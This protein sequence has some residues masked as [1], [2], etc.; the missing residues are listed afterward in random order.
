[1]NYSILFDTINLEPH[2]WNIGDYISSL[3]TVYPHIVFGGKGALEYSM[4][5]RTPD[6]CLYLLYSKRRIAN[7]SDLVRMVREKDYISLKF[8]VSD[9]KLTNWIITI[10]E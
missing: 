1:M 9:L 2:D 5:S 7:D 4:I 10:T 3:D 8:K 6:S